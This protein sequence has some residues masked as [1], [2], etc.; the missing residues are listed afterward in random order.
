MQGRCCPDV[1]VSSREDICPN[2]KKQKVSRKSKFI[3]LAVFIAPRC[4][5][6]DATSTNPLRRVAGLA[7]IDYNLI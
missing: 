7:Y 1:L 2:I 6:Q 3:I 5:V 4:I